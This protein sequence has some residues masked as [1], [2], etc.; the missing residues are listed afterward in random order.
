MR[1]RRDEKDMM[2]LYGISRTDGSAMVEIE[3]DMKM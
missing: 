1:G 2:V 3:G